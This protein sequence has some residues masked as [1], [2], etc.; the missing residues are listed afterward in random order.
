MK[1]RYNSVFAIPSD[2]IVVSIITVLIILFLLAIII[3][4]LWMVVSSFKTT[5]EIFSDI[6][7]L[8]ETWQFQNYVT[9]WNT[10]IARYF[11]N[12]LIVTIATVVL[13]VVVCSLISFSLVNYKIKGAKAIYSFVVLG[14]M[15]SPIVSIFPL[16]QEIQNLGL[17]NTRLSLILIYT[18]YQIPM[19]FMLIYAFFKNIDKAYL[20]AARIDGATD[21][22]ILFRVFVPLSASIFMVSIVL[23][24]F[25]AW[26]EF[27]FALVFVKADNL[28]TIP[29]GLLAFQG[30]MYSDWGV[31][32]A[33][34]VISALPIIVLYIFAQKYFISGLTAGGVKG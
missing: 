11:L 21:L 25:Y 32:L 26:N 33:G 28:M 8:P 16:Y 2:G 3:P 14:L 27:T 10:G 15:F 4:L 7:T 34:L 29:V 23:T 20:D 22:Q 17:Y 19:S 18:A 9:A 13:N 12:S 5:N 24:S 31:L 6:W 30:E 1:K